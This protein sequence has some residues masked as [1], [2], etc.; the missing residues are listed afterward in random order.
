MKVL[1]GFLINP[2]WYL[3]LKKDFEGNSEYLKGSIVVISSLAIFFRLFFNSAKVCL[4]T[5]IFMLVNFHVIMLLIQY[6]RLT[7]YL[8]C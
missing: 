7:S 2:M 5:L 1:C 3:T 4:Y 6:N 8:T